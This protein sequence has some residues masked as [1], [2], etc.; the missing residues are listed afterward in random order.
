M[1]RRRVSGG[2]RRSRAPVAWV[3]NVFNETAMDLA[4]TLTELNVLDVD[5]DLVTAAP[6]NYSHLI[7]RVIVNGGL[8]IVPSSTTGASDMVSFY[9]AL[10]V[11]DSDDS[12]AT[13][14]VGTLGSLLG[15][16]RVLHAGCLSF[17]VREETAGAT[18]VS[19]LY[20]LPK[21]E[22]DVKVNAKIRPDEFL[23]LGCQFGSAA[24]GAISLAAMSAYSRV[25]V[26]AP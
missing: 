22:I 19:A 3:T 23:V 2:G 14:L 5:V 1:A 10:Y 8:A 4:G 7:R 18:G 9:Y 11:I 15:A 6:L 17:T 12:D 21:I 16:R 20:W 24:S 26:N 13:I 25:L